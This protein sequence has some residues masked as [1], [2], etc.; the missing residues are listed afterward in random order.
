M[1]VTIFRWLWPLC[2]FPQENNIY[3]WI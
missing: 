3:V 2:S 1:H